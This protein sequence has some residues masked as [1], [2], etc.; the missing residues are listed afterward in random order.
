MRQKDHI[1]RSGED[2]A[3]AWL[4]GE[5]HELLDRNWRCEFGEIDL[6]T[7]D[8]RDIVCTEVKT[9]RSL[10]AGHPLEAI[11]PQKLARMRRCAGAWAAAH[12]ETPGRL[13]LDAIGLVLRDGTPPVVHYRRAV[14]LQ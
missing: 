4:L 8:G 7:R 12:P 11:T 1:G 6:V 5:G 9:R 3:A 14:G 13:R 10:R 2:A